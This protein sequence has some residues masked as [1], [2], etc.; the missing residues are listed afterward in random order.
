VRSGLSVRLS[1][2]V[3]SGLSFRLSIGVRSILSVRLRSGT[4]TGLGCVFGVV[5][6]YSILFC[7]FFHCHV[8]DSL[9]FIYKI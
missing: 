7:P 6:I 8:N 1:V 3:R 4:S 2:I 5:L 9:A